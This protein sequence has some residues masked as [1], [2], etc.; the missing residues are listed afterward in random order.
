MCASPRGR[1]RAPPANGSGRQPGST[2][3][4]IV[5]A[6]FIRQGYSLDSTYDAPPRLVLPG[7]EADGSDWQD[8]LGTYS[9]GFL[10]LWCL[11]AV[12]STIALYLHN[13]PEHK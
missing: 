3:K 6:E 4:P 12:A 11:A 13:G 9:L 8:H 5:L 7:A 1:W 2:F 10:G